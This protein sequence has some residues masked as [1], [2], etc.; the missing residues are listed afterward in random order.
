M[1][2]TLSTE[3]VHRKWLLQLEDF[4]E[5]W[6]RKMESM[7]AV[8]ILLAIFQGKLSAE[9]RNLPVFEDMPPE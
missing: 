8:V 5:L 6:Q 7:I 3:I 1:L 4:G 9:D 2:E